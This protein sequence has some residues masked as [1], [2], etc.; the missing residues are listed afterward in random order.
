MS[1]LGF[2]HMISISSNVD[3]DKFETLNLGIN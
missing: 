3:L 1:M 2:V